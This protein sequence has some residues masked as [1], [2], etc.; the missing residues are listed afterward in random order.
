VGKP[1]LFSLKKEVMIASDT[2]DVLR[3]RLGKPAIDIAERPQIFL[4]KTAKI[5]AMNQDIANRDG[6]LPMLSVRISDDANGC[7]FL[8]PA[9]KLRPSPA[10]VSTLR[11]SSNPKAM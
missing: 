10:H 6:D 8:G 9:K 11:L 5:A 1:E 7:H 3:G 4:L 2:Q